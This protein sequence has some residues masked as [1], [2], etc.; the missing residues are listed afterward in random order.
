MLSSRTFT[1]GAQRLARA[2]IS[3][4]ATLACW[5]VVPVAQAAPVYRHVNATLNALNIEQFALDVNQ[6]G[7]TDFTFTAA[8]APDPFF[9]V[10]FDTVDVP[11]GS[12]NAFVIDSPTFNGFPTITRLMAGAVVSSASQFSSSGD[13][14]NLFFSTPFDPDSGNFGGQ[15]G[16]VGLRF[17]SGVPGTFFYGFAEVSVVGINAASNQLDLSIGTVGYDNLAGQAIQ[18]PFAVGAPVSEPGSLALLGAGG[19][20]LLLVRRRRQQRMAG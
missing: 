19:F 8:Y 6:N 11:F 18:I 4:A 2:A 17:V 7:T 5:A 15:S 9:T 16:Y 12:S 1:A 20:G 3:I 10:G 13:Q 14:G